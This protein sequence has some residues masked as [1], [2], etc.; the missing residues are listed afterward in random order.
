MVEQRFTS[1]PVLTEPVCGKMCVVTYLSVRLSC[2]LNGC[3]R[4]AYL[5][6]R[7]DLPGVTL[8]FVTSYEFRRNGWHTHRHIIRTIGLQGATV[9]PFTPAGQDCR[10]RLYVDNSRA[11]FRTKSAVQHH[12]DSRLALRVHAAS[13]CREPDTLRIGT[14]AGAKRSN[15]AESPFWDK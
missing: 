10:A 3:M 1:S 14:E 5:N 9:H 7:G 4:F 13:S 11:S 8:S 6:V 2:S 12:W 15:T